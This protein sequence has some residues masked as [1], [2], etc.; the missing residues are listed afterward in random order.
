MNRLENHTIIAGTN[1]SR[2]WASRD[3]A[4]TTPCFYDE[5]ES[6]WAGYFQDQIRLFN[7]RMLLTLGGRYDKWT[8]NDGILTPRAATNIFFWD[9]KITTR[10]AAGRS[11]RRPSFDVPLSTKIIILLI[12][13]EAGLRGLMSPQSPEMVR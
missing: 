2:L 10:L 3:I 9:K 8:N 5:S 11:F 4:N 12:S 7:D 6:L 13:P 1:F